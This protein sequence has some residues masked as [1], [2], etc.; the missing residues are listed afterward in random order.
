MYLSMVSL[1][2]CPRAVG[3]RPG[4]YSIGNQPLTAALQQVLTM[5]A[6]AGMGMGPSELAA[7]YRE[8]AATCIDLAHGQSA[9][10]EKLWLLDM[11]QSWIDLADL[12]L[13]NEGRQVLYETPEA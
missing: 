5:S 7:R 4:F 1:L 3:I 6:Y 13:K 9:P 12:T 11:A 8:Y 10:S 2:Q